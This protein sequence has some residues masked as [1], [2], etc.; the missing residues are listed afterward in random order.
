MPKLLPA[1]PPQSGPP[2]RAVE[3]HGSLRRTDPFDHPLRARRDAAAG[4]HVDPRP[5]LP[6]V[7]HADRDHRPGRGNRR[8][9]GGRL[10]L[11][12]RHAPRARLRQGPARCQVGRGRRPSGVLADGRRDAGPKPSGAAG[13]VLRRRLRDHGP[14]Q[15]DGGGSGGAAGLGELF[16]VGF[17]RVS[18][19]GD[20]RGARALPTIAC[21]VSW[22]PG[23]SARSRAW[24]STGRSQRRFACRS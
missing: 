20:P 14:G 13:R 12:R 10:L 1:W 4:D 19:A 24:T 15:R 8:P 18:A 5:G 23:T 7:R 11:L 22:R 16:G 2:P 6:G 21:K 9:A 17:P 3:H